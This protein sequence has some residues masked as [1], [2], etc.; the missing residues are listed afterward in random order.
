MS[1]QG[2]YARLAEL[3]EVG[4]VGAVPV[5]EGAV[6]L[7]AEAEPASVAPGEVFRVRYRWRCEQPVEQRLT[8]R[9]E[10]VN[11]RWLRARGDPGA[12]LPPE[13]RQGWGTEHAFLYGV[14]P[15]E[16]NAPGRHYEQVGYYVAAREAPP[17]AYLM[18][19]AI[20]PPQRRSPPVP[21]ARVDLEAAP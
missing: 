15:L 1:E 3:A 2:A 5:G 11:A 7:R 13:A 8:L 10:F 6:L 18:R 20:N 9:V 21:V 17:G 19:V 16:A 14:R 12:E 4:E